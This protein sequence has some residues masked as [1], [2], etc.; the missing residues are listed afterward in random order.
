M[1]KLLAII[2]LVCLCGCMNFNARVRDKSNAVIEPYSCTAAACSFCYVIAVPQVMADT[3]GCEF[4]AMN[5]ITIPI[6]LCCFAVDVPLELVCDTVCLPYDVY[7]T[8]T[9]D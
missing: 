5:I 4:E 8:C 3:A 7:R 9:K 1:K 6:G 2:G